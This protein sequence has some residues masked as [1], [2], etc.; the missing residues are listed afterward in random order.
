MLCEVLKDQ[1]GFDGLV[2]SDWCAARSTG[3]AA[4]GGLDLVMPG[5]G[6][7]GATS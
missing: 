6:G 7:P 2:M 4:N 3:A 1:W 5:P